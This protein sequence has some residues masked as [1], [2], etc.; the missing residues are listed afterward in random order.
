MKAV[1]VAP[2]AAVQGDS[3]EN[4][5]RG[6]VDSLY[7]A[8]A[9]T[10]G[11]FGVAREVTDEAMLRAYTRWEVVGAY[12]NPAGWVYRV[13]LNLATSRWRRT[14]RERPLSYL[15]GVASVQDSPDPA[16]LVALGALAGLSVRYRVV[17]VARVLLDL[18]TR[19]TAALLDLPEGTVKSR[20]ARALESLRREL[21]TGDDD[22][23]R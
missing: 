9:V 1:D 6:Q 16:G 18:S 3:F 11:D 5:Y 15:E 21:G 2:T 14:R 19:E 7:R 17:V 12:D 13:G 10:L 20:L 22:D 23:A 4:F 8:L